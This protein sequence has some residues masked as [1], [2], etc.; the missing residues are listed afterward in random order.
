[1]R[2]R[3]TATSSSAVFHVQVFLELEALWSRAQAFQ[4]TLNPVRR[5]RTILPTPRLVNTC[6][7]DAIDKFTN[8][9][10]KD[11][12]RLSSIVDNISKFRKTSQA[13]MPTSWNKTRP[14]IKGMQPIDLHNVTTMRKASALCRKQE[15]EPPKGHDTRNKR[16]DAATR[17]S[18]EGARDGE[19]TRGVCTRAAQGSSSR[20][21]STMASII[22]IRSFRC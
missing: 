18:E 20:T 4:A 8:E 1:M 19:L 21:R 13:W 10:E 15:L 5:P 9:C 6:V 11:D 14:D 3:T 12:M 22:R 16:G 2:E 17:R 7:T